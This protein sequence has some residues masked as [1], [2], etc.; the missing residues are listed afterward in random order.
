MTGKMIL[1]INTSTPQFSIA[2][3]EM[4]GSLR[5]EVILTP[6]EKT[7]EYSRELAESMA[8]N[9]GYHILNQFANPDNYL[10]HY[11]TT[12]PEIWDDTDRKITHFVSAMGTT[13][14]IMGVSR[15]LKEQ[16]QSVQ[17]VGCQP[18]EGSN[19]PGIRRWS[20]EFMPKIY[21]PERVD[22]I[23]D[24]SSIKELVKRWY[25]EIPHFQKQKSHLALDDIK[26]SIEE[27]KYYRQQVFLP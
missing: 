9:E 23:I 19:I 17:I 4:S 24:V 27:L 5:A 20:P 2:L 3:L 14:T 18:T 12:G 25:P 10:M 1:A 22:R 26:E 21:E 6:A 11:H 13:G 8:E 15:Y 7:I 16:N